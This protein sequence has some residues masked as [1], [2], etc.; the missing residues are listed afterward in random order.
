MHFYRKIIG[1]EVKDKTSIV[2]HSDHSGGL[3]VRASASETSGVGS[4]HGRV[5]E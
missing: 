4:I 3:V 5:S 2:I 1:D